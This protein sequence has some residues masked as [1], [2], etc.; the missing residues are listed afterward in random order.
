MILLVFL[1]LSSVFPGSILAKG[2]SNQQADLIFK[3]GEVYTVDEEKSWAEA[4]AVKDGEI[5]YV[6]D[7]EGVESFQGPETQVNDLD[8]NML[9]PGFIDGH[10][11]AYLKA[12]ELF[13]LDLRPYST[14]EEFA[15]AIDKYLEENPG[16]E[17]LRGVYSDRSFPDLDGITPREFLDGMV[18]DIPAVFIENG[19]HTI[20]VNSNAIE[21]AEVT[22]DTPDPPGGIIDRDETGEPNGIFHEFSAQN[23]IIEALPQPDFTVDEYKETVLSFQE[24]AAE[25]GVTSVFVPVHYPTEPL[26]EALQVLDDANELTVRYD[27][28]LWADENKGLEQIETFKEKRDKYQGRMYK[29]NSIKIFGT[30][31]RGRGLVWE[32][33]VLE[34]TVAALDKEGFRLYTHVISDLDAYH[35]ILDAY[36]YALEEN[37]A[38][39][40]RHTISHTSSNGEGAIDRFKELNV[41]ADGHPVPASFFEAGIPASTSNDYPVR[42]FW[43]LVSVE[44]GVQNFSSSDLD[45]VETMLT[46]HT[47]N[48]ANLI[49]AEEETGSIEVG[50]KA[51]F[52]VLENNLFEVPVSEIS[53]TTTLMTYFEGQEVFRHAS[54]MSAS[55]IN[56]LV[57][58]FEEDGEFANHGAARSLQAHLATVDRFE[59]REAADKVVKHTQSFNKLLDNHQKNELISENASNILKAN[60]NSLINKW[61]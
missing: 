10:N 59:Q 12:E 40:S 16:I 8:G 20:W 55:H 30:G 43:P 47:I 2:N 44:K 50:K 9:M 48:G 31:T 49:F 60:A 15:N 26:L 46:S 29:T 3:N 23:L 35:A 54:R 53:E 22:K 28:A 58:Q 34:E 32:Q 45:G 24:M 11:H 17:Q 19:H 42:D 38:R 39:D 36:E 56:T 18:S 37:G 14:Q 25:R 1:L 21:N 41:I 27:I 4:V 33:D 5:V 57:E 13:W 51:D 61:E 52:V 7:S 6:G